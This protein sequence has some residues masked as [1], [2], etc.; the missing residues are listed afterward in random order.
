MKAILTQSSCIISLVYH[1]SV[2]SFNSMSHGFFCPG[3][4]EILSGT[5]MSAFRPFC[6]SVCVH[7]TLV[8]LK[9]KQV[10]P[11]VS[12]HRAAFLNC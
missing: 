6:F 10:K 9:Y 2:G 1:F 5:L 8:A 3:A 4:E 11:L 12:R 7:D